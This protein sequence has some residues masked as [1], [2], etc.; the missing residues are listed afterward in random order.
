MNEKPVVSTIRRTRGLL[1]LLEAHAEAESA[2]SDPWQLAVPIEILRNHEGLTLA[3]IRW[4]ISAGLCEYALETTRRG[5]RRSYRRG[6][7]LAACGRACFVLTA[8]GLVAAQNA[9]S[10]LERDAR[11]FSGIATPKPVWQASTGNLVLDSRLVK[12][13]AEN[14]TAQR[15][16]LDAFQNADWTNPVANPFEEMPPTE[17]SRYLRR[18]IDELNQ[19][20]RERKM[21][22]ASLGKATQ[23]RWSIVE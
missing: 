11:L 7:S 6:G 1:R 23:I 19:H 20:H 5:P 13:L 10:P 15:A 21:H 9:C 4:L 8:Q 16:V 18:L 22:F 3:D 12:H 17:R 2:S 14:A